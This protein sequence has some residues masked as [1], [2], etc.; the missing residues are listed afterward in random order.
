MS[1][2]DI[3]KSI[4]SLEDQRRLNLTQST[5][6]AIVAQLM[7]EGNLSADENDRLTLLKALDGLDRTTIATAKVKAEDNAARANEMIAERMARFLASSHTSN[8]SQ[9]RTTE[10]EE[11]ELPEIE[12]VEGED[13]IGVEAVEYENMMS[14]DFSPEDTPSKDSD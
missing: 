4:F 10:L 3:N 2:N 13:T 8:Q 12:I 9:V 5:R 14:I 1:D 7:P 11:Y 6:E